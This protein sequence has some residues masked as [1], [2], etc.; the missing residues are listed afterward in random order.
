MY[1]DPSNTVP[2]GN[3]VT[4]IPGLNPRFPV[5]TVAPVL[6]TVEPARTAKLPAVASGTGSWAFRQTEN[7]AKRNIALNF[8]MA[9][10]VLSPRNYSI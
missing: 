1:S 7:V 9:K 6:V 2:G 3:P 10:A 8:R 4:E 5:T